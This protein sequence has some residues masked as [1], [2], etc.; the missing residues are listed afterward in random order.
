MKNETISIIMPMYN[1]QNI[2]NNVSIVEQELK[3][4]NLNYEVL[5]VDDGSTNTCLEQANK[6]SSKNVNVVGYKKNIGKGF[7]LIY[8][9]K[10][11]KGDY[12]VFLDSDLDLHPKTIRDFLKYVP[13]YDVVIGSKRHPKSNVHY[14]LS[15]RLLSRLTQLAV[16]TLF[17]LNVKDTQVG[18]KL[19]KRK[20][21][22][23]IHQKLLVK[24]WAF[25]LELLVNA[26][27]LHYKI[28]ERP[29]ELKF[30]F[31]SKIKPSAIFWSFV[32]MLAIFYRLK[33]L[34]YYDKK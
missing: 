31:S 32:D 28:I 11:T 33:I 12:I 23:D 24:K 1:E 30:K 21:L 10:Y 8:G 15:R 13:E 16:K 6:I 34:R 5:V 22:E 26:N 19:F 2:E 18:F 9:F 7:A 14:P 4:L 27:K 17:N 29:I 25:D 3:N 20:V